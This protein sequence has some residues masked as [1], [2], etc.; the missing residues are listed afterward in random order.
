MMYVQ[1]VLKKSAHFCFAPKHLERCFCTFFNSPAF[2]ELRNN[3][4][5]R[6]SKKWGIS[7]CYSVCFTAH[8][9][10][11]LENSFIIH[12]KIDIQ[13][14]Y[15]FWVILRSWEIYISLPDSFVHNVYLYSCK[16]SSNTEPISILYLYFLQ[17]AR[18]VG[19]GAVD[20]QGH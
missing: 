6:V 19:V 5:Y 1:G 12:L 9:I 13:I 15:H 10:W 17:L 8:L 4:I 18:A 7:G 20:L 16:S 2:V 11:N 14:Q 3:N